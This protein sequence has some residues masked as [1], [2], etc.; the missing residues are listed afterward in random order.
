LDGTQFVTLEFN[1]FIVDDEGKDKDDISLLFNE[2]LFVSF[3]FKI[4]V[5]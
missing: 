3:P 4:G 1:P 5:K 2:E